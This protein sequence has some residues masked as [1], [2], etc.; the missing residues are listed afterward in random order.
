MRNTSLPGLLLWCALV[1]FTIY[2]RGAHVVLSYQCGL[3]PVAAL[4]EPMRPHKGACPHATL[5]HYRR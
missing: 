5:S 3:N 2:Q 1:G 4:F